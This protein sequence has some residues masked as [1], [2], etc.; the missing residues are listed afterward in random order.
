VTAVAVT[1][2]VVERVKITEHFLAIE[3]ISV[4][5]PERRARPRVA[6]AVA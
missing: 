6:Q 3:Y 5:P 4:R 1:T 2:T